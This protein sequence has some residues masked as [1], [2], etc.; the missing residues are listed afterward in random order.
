M[1]A[2]VVPT[3]GGPDAMTVRTVPRPVPS[4]DQLLVRVRAAA[5]N[6]ADLLQRAGE[7]PAPPGESDVLGVEIAGDVV[8]AGANA[9]ANAAAGVG[10]AVFGLVGGGGYADGCLIDAGMAIPIPAGLSYAEAAALPEVCFTA[11]TAL[12]QLGGLS[13]GQTVLIHGGASGLGTAA[14][15]MAK[16]AG[17]RVACTVGSAQKAER[18]RALGADLAI[19]Y[20]EQDFVTGV[21]AW[22]EGAGVDVIVDIVGTEYFNRNLAALKDGGCLVQV[23]VMSGTRCD[24]DLDTILFKRLQIKGTIMR[25]LPIG[26][27]RRITRRFR[28]RWLPHVMDGSLRPV[29]DSIH[30]I[31][32]VASAHRRLEQSRHIGKIILDLFEA[33]EIPHPRASQDQPPSGKKAA[34]VTR[35]IINDVKDTLLDISRYDLELTGPDAVQPG[36]L[37]RRIADFMTKGPGYCVCHGT[38]KLLAARGLDIREDREV[39]LALLESLFRNAMAL[40]DMA[41]FSVTPR[42]MT[43]NRMDVCG[44]NLNRNFSHD[45]VVQSRA[46]MTSKCLHF[47]AATPFVANLYGPNENIAGGKPVICD[48]RKYC[49][50][51]GIRARDIVENIP[52]NYN[53]AIKA[54]AYDVLMDEYSVALDIDVDNDI[55]GIMQLNEIEGGVAHAATDPR[56]IDESAPARRPIRHIE[57]QYTEEDHYTEWY[58]HYG[59]DV[60]EAKDYAG[61]NLSLDY[62][63]PATK[64]FDRMVRV[65]N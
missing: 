14:I 32:A 56:K 24:L 3:P 42:P 48:V 43:L 57:Y 18:T 13:E 45:G 62:H 6:Q 8:A 34:P 12:F 47:D 60:L 26:E 37:P 20:T 7:F 46:F 27:K 55:I 44:F 36:D 35:S 38:G 29:V 61:E 31:R 2:V 33:R 19:V 23:G 63:K 4:P 9:A 54:S 1:R 10:A 41:A 15:Q 11:D 50:D 59:L 5:L 28:D 25:P 17:A 40:V 58:R 53:I 65:G 16:L 30:P 52:N 49:A 39:A 51:H 21:L 64:P 22:T